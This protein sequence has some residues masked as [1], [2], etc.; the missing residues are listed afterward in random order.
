MERI[1]KEHIPQLM[2]QPV[3]IADKQSQL[4]GMILEVLIDI[5][6]GDKVVQYAPWHGAGG[7][8]GNV[9]GGNAK[10]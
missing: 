6:D 7:G 3:G 10:A 9:D 4:L 2:N 8:G 5:R 1:T